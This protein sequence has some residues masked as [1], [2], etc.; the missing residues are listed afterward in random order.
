MNAP[1][2]TVSRIAHASPEAR[3]ARLAAGRAGRAFA[4]AGLAG[5]LAACGGGGGAGPE[6][7]VVAEVNRD[8]T[9]QGAVVKGPVAAGQV[10]AY[11]V[12]DG[13]AGE[14]RGC[15]STDADGRYTI[16]VLSVNPAGETLVVAATRLTG[17][18]TDE[19]TGTR[20]A[21]D[22]TLRTAV[23]LRPGDAATAMVTPLTELAMRRAQT[24]PGGLHASTIEPAMTLVSAAF[25]AGDLR[26]VR[27]ADPTHP[28]SAQAARGA[29]NHGLALAAVSSLQ[30][31]L[32]APAG[33]R[34]TLEQALAELEDAFAPDRVA[35][36]DTKFQAALQ[37][38][39][40]GPRNASGVA[41][42]AMAQAVALN[43]S[44]LPQAFGVLPAIEPAGPATITTL[45]VQPDD[46]P[47]CRV[48]VSQP[49][50]G[51]S[52]LIPMQ[53]FT[54]CVRRVQPAQCEVGTM[55]GLLRGDKLYNVL[56]GT[57]FRMTEHAVQATDS[58]GSGADA[59]IDLG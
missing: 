31:T 12:V 40:A 29:R 32:S 1:S 55:Q 6:G 58:C 24:A 11:A 25:D 16:Q 13:V 38:F 48:T 36:Q 43:L 34:V 22:A 41:P 8:A 10:C 2:K 20:R 50:V 28:A 4:A 33:K 18:Y 9:I 57:A 23:Q 46:G 45:P 54:F 17:Q 21:L 7:P 5:L 53:P 14:R 47:A 56:Q 30:D 42:G 44:A 39:L 27:P 3:R 51:G 37:A 26:Q 52:Y 19:A 35:A 49:L 59:T 15:A